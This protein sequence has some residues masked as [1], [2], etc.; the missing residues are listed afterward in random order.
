MTNG[1]FQPD[2]PAYCISRTI[3]RP[4][5]V[6]FFDEDD[7]PTRRPPPRPRRPAPAGRTPGPTQQELLVRRAGA[8][9]IG[10]LL[11]IL[12][13]V[14]INACQDSARKNALRDYNSSVSSIIDA[15]DQDV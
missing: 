13:I 3:E 15:S 4:N 7:E 14:F 12:L 2:P 8:A 11:L 6:S 5:R 1:S 9:A 10:V